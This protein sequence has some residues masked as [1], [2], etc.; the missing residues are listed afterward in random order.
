LYDLKPS[1]EAVIPG[2]RRKES[3]EKRKYPSTRMGMAAQL[4][5]AFI[6]ARDYES[7][8]TEY[9]KKRSS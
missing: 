6:D 2:Q 1:S 9:E 8:L 7:K 5:Q 3:W 4:R